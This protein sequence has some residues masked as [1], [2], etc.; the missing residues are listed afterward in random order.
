MTKDNIYTPRNI[1]AKNRIVNDVVNQRYNNTALSKIR[2]YLAR[3][4]KNNTLSSPESLVGICLW[5]RMMPM[6]EFKAKYENMT[7]LFKLV[8]D[9]GQKTSNKKSVLEAYVHIPEI[10][11]MLPKPDITIIDEY[12]ELKKEGKNSSRFETISKDAK[13]EFVKMTYYP[14]FYR[15]FDA[16]SSGYQGKAVEVKSLSKSGFNTEAVGVFVKLLDNS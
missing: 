11:G 3:I 15:A 6:Q 5:S 16:I 12:F 1:D 13:K 2:N 9:Q 4:K 8:T 10:T 14:R 7:T